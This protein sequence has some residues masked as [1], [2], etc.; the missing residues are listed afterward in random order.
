M[1]LVCVKDRARS[2]TFKVSF[3]AMVAAAGGASSIIVGYAGRALFAVTACFE[4]PQLLAGMHVFWLTLSSRILKARGTATITGALKGL[5][6]ATLNSHL[7]IFAF[8]VSLI[9][10]AVADAVFAVLDSKE[11]TVYFAGGLSAA[12]NVIVLQ[13]FFLPE[14][15]PL[16]Y[17]LA[18]L[19]AFSSGLFF[20]GYLTNHVVKVAQT[21]SINLNNHARESYA[22]TSNE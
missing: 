12:S 3:L 22:K 16:V 9:E 20:G 2:A 10:G 15:P 8:L 19:A 4:A 5:V 18:Y 17:A 11:K 21:M 6:E 14:A 7:G 1:S 13:V